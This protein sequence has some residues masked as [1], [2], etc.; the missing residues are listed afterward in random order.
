VSGT[1]IIQQFNTFGAAH[2][3]VALA[4]SRHQRLW[5]SH[6]YGWVASLSRRPV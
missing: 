3:Q 4:G 1:F 5:S 6:L 2:M